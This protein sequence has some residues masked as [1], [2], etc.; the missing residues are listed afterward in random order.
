[1]NGLPV[2][3]VS[4]SQWNRRMIPTERWGNGARNEALRLARRALGAVGNPSLERAFLMCSTLCYHRGATDAEVAAIP[5]GP[6]G[7]AGP[8]F[9]Q[10]IYETEAVPPVSLSFTPCDNR[11][12]QTRRRD[13]SVL[14]LPVD[15]CEECPSCQARDAI[16]AS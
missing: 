10:V 14:K 2:W 8:P 12:F 1:M 4:I 3:L 15:D 11:R 5:P 6:G 16:L 13:G 7:L 9:D